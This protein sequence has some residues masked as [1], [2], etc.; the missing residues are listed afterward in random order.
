MGGLWGLLI[1]L[2]ASCSTQ[3]TTSEQH[4]EDWISDEHVVQGS[5]VLWPQIGEENFWDVSAEGPVELIAGKALYQWDR[6]QLKEVVGE[7]RWTK[8]RINWAAGLYYSANERYDEDTV[9]ALFSKDG[10]TWE[11]F[12][13]PHKEAYL[14]PGLGKRIGAFASVDD[15]TEDIS[16]SHLEGWYSENLKAWIP[17]WPPVS[18]YFFATKAGDSLF[19]FS[20]PTRNDSIISVFST[21]NYTTWDSLTVQLPIPM[22]DMKYFGKGDN[23]YLMVVESLDKNE[24]GENIHPQTV[25]HSQDLISWKISSLKILGSVNGVFWDGVSWVIT[26]QDAESVPVQRISRSTD[27]MHWSTEELKIGRNFVDVKNV[28]DL[29]FRPS[30]DY[31]GAYYSWK[32]GSL[33]P[34]PD[35]E[36]R[37]SMDDISQRS[38]SSYLFVGEKGLVGSFDPRKDSVKIFRS[39]PYTFHQ[40]FKLTTAYVASASRM[41]GSV[42]SLASSNGKNWKE[43]ALPAGAST[44]FVCNEKACISG[45]LA[46]QDGVIWQR[47]DSTISSGRI[48]ATSTKFFS[49]YSESKSNTLRV[50][51]STD[52]KSWTE[53]GTTNL[54]GS[55][56]DWDLLGD[57]M[58][59]GD[60]WSTDGIT[61]KSLFPSDT[62]S[63]YPRQL[64]K[65]EEGFFLYNPT[66]K[67]L[68]CS[69]DLAEWKTCRSD[70]FSKFHLG[71]FEKIESLG[72]SIYLVF[73]WDGYYLANLKTKA[74]ESLGSD[75]RWDDYVRTEDGVIY[76]DDDRIR[77]LIF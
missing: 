37:W 49:Y 16:S 15:D 76:P 72:D 26:N 50:R 33:L 38:D 67:K 53:K 32:G 73:S 56:E 6:D 40:V 18:H 24:S 39:N 75:P 47:L 20:F 69:Q 61:W 11:T 51:M 46:S 41:G 58:I 77:K 9:C 13:L 7:D 60:M 31:D 44:K 12:S 68:Y 5:E 27:G 74:I 63:S 52:A 36:M 1:F 62:L 42:Y 21:S 4:Q 55:L 48:I 8:G 29:L 64:W 22:Y 71:T 65:T 28:G 35:E 2:I 59:V 66:K 25:L 34:F 70:I 17:F 14:M 54:S 57:H 23:D 45:N 3:N 43:T 19:L 30:T 10:L